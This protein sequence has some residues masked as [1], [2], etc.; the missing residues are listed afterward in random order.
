MSPA[1]QCGDTALDLSQPRIMGILNITP[2]SFSDGGFF[3]SPDKALAQ[4]ER[5][6]NEGAAIIDIGGESTRPGAESVS[7]QEEL[8]RVIPVIE[9]IHSRLDT[10][11]S[12]DTSKPAVMRAAVAAG[13]GMV[14]DVCALQAE[15]AVQAVQQAGVPVCLMHMQG[16]PRSMQNRPHYTNVVAEVKSFLQQRAAAC[17]DG[18]I[19]P[20]RIVLDPGFGFGKTLEHNYS[21]IKHLTDFIEMGY[22][23]LVGLSR[24]SMI[25]A[26]LDR[27]VDER[28]YGSI[29]LA[30]LACWSGAHIL[31]VHDVGATRD[32]IKVCHAARRAD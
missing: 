14:N 30:A 26:V 25:G 29:A 11:I 12:I 22:P 17:V 27:S 7:V 32:A 6:I 15:G 3:M 18:G 23:L 20:S 2:D 31:R 13:A 16:E 24:K 8:D 9:A 28:I 10:I 4:A 5:M 19:D 1:L 21:L